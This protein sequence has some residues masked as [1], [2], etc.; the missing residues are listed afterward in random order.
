MNQ[1]ECGWT[2]WCL[3]LLSILLGELACPSFFDFGTIKWWFA[4]AVV[5]MVVGFTQP[6]CQVLFV[7]SFDWRSFNMFPE[8]HSTLSARKNHGYILDERFHLLFLLCGRVVRVICCY[9]VKKCPCWSTKGNKVGGFFMLPRWRWWWWG[10]RWFGWRH[11]CF[12]LI[13][14]WKRKSLGRSCW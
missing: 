2:M 5:H 12:F 1:G 6:L 13:C 4:K 7:I 11:D 8:V 10:W 9:S 3:A 14:V